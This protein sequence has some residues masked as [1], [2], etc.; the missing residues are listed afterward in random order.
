[1][2]RQASKITFIS[3]PSTSRNGRICRVLHNEGSKESFVNSRR[4]GTRCCMEVFLTGHR[5][6]RITQQPTQDAGT[7]SARLEGPNNGEVVR[8]NLHNS[9]SILKRNAISRDSD[10]KRP[11]SECLTSL[12]PMMPPRSCMRKNRLKVLRG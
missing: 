3:S 9:A 7:Y 6:R 2:T 5:A 11:Q 10:V 1:M 8:S 4:L 12:V